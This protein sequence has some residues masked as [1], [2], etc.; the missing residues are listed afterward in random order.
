MSLAALMAAFAPAAAAL[1]LAPPPGGSPT[2][3]AWV[4][5]GTAS[6]VGYYQPDP[7]D[8]ELVYGENVYAQRARLVRWMA[9]APLPRRLVVETMFPHSARPARGRHRLLAFIGR[10]RNG[11]YGVLWATGDGPG[12]ACIP[13]DILRYFTVAGGARTAEG[14]LCL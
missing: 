8:G 5:L 12:P 10:L 6:Y 13:S 7:D 11:H 3:L 9:G 1:T 2:S 14:A 4:E